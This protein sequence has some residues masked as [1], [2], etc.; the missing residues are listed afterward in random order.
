MIEHYNAFISYKHEPEDI[1][2]AKTIQKSLERYHIPKKLRDSTG[3]KE[4]SDTKKAYYGLD[5]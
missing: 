1:K 3:G 2:I 5:D 4:L